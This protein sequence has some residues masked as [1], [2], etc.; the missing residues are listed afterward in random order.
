MILGFRV[1]LSSLK[2]NLLKGFAEPGEGAP[3]EVTCQII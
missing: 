3:I 2:A 1:S